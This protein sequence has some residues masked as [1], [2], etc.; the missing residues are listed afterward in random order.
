VSAPSRYDEERLAGLLSLLPP[1]PTGWVQ[2]AQEL[3]GARLELDEIV[4]RA[5]VDL[6][7][8]VLL[9]ADLEAALAEAGYEPTDELIDAVRA[10][11]PE[12]DQ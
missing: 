6:E 7:F 5:R 10:C 9:V 2:A 11:L 4:E 1:A 12:L 8:R 3:P